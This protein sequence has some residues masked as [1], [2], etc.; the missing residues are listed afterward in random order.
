MV[1]S[2]KTD[3]LITVDYFLFQNIYYKKTGNTPSGRLYD[4]YQ[5]H[6]KRL[7][8]LGIL[9]TQ[10][11]SEDISN[12]ANKQ[13]GENLDEYQD[14]DEV[15]VLLAYIFTDKYLNF[16]MQCDENKLWLQLNNSPWSE[17]KRRWDNTFKLKRREI[18]DPNNNTTEILKKWPLYKHSDGFT[19]VSLH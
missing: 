13:S 6:T 19:L 14:N 17:V 7:R 5:N 12:S 10:R 15:N 11:R 8:K 4:K 18:L 3:T 16:Y 9:S 1:V 2:L